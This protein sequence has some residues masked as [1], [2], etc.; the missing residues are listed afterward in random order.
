MFGFYNYNNNYNNNR[1]DPG[2]VFASFLTF[3]VILVFIGILAAYFGGIILMIF[4]GIGALM[5]LLYAIIVYV[6]AFV[7]ACKTLSSVSGKNAFTTF[8]LRWWNLLKNSAIGAFKNNFSIAHNALVQA[9]GYRFLSFRK[10]MWF[11]VAPSVLVFG[12]AMILFMSLL[13]LAVMGTLFYFAFIF[14]LTVFAVLLVVATVFSLIKIVPT[15]ATSFSGAN[16]FSTVKFKRK[17]KFSDFIAFVKNYY[18]TLAKWVVKVWNEGISLSSAAL[19]N[20][21]TYHP[22]NPVRYF[23]IV[24]PLAIMAISILAIAIVF[25]ALSIV[26]VPIALA[27][28]VWVL[29]CLIIK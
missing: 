1:P 11:I 5:G 8:L 10:W 27:Q 14:L 22:I 17:F 6:Q 18:I 20:A 16:P 9:G 24:S 12:T 29:I 13:Q 26:F 3:L 7:N 28:L 4:L 2:D 23:L 25:V 21:P 19:S 15:S